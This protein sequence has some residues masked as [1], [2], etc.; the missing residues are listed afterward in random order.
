MNRSIAL[1]CAVLCTVSFANG[2]T[3]DLSA[4]AHSAVQDSEIEEVVV[5]ARKRAEPISEVPMAVSAVEA[6]GIWE[7][8]VTEL[9]QLEKQLPNTVQTNFGQGNTNQAVV[10]IRGTGMQDHIITTDPSVGIYLDGVYLGR[11]VGANIDLLGIDRIEVARGPQ[12]T[13]S[14]RN[15]LGGAVHIVTRKP[16]GDGTRRV[17]LRAGSLGRLSVG[18][19]LDTAIGERSD[20][21]VALGFKSRNGIGEA[22]LI[23]RPEAEVGEIHQYFGRLSWYWAVQDNTNVRLIADY[24][25]ARQGITPHEVLV[26]AEPNSLGLRQQDQPEDPNDT[27]SLNEELMS[28]DDRSTGFALIVDSELSERWSWKTTIGVRDMWFDAGLDNE[29]IAPSLLEF[30]ETGESDQLSFEYQLSSVSDRGEWISGLYYFEEDG[31]N[32]SPFIFRSLP[33]SSDDYFVPTSDFE[34][35][36]FVEQQTTSAALFSHRTMDLTEKVSIG[37]GL[38]HTRDD[39]KAGAFL[40]YFPEKVVK[41]KSWSETTGDVSLS[42]RFNRWSNGYASFA[43]GYQAGGFPPRPFAGPSVFVAFDPTFANSFELG[44]KYR[45]TRGTELN[46]S[47]FRVGYTDLAVQVSELIEDGFLTLT[48]NA[49]RSVGTGIEADGQLDLNSWLGLQFAVGLIDIEISEVDDSVQD[50]RAGDSPSLTPDFTLSLMPTVHYPLSHGAQLVGRMNWYT[51]GEMYG[52]PVNTRHNKMPS[53]SV[54]H[55]NVDYESAG[56]RWTIGGYVQNATDEQYPL[57]KLDLYPTALIIN[58][59]D[60]RE[61]GVRLRVDLE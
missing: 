56:G 40:H 30:P 24:S 15:T 43:R 22:L 4:D 51:R 57:A 42:Y 25:T 60:V 47:V 13:F 2:G 7:R 48:R 33:S 34:G 19:L 52:E 45:N 9:N 41:E 21:T 44:W 3:A 23:D 14:G 50:I 46:L 55:L 54:V 5:T 27:Y 39:K 37:L 53:I 17:D 8:N 35:L 12:G 31:Y 49:A 28:T 58:S 6:W 59:N 11:N 16:V 36:L 18:G 1:A 32:D 29:K 20:L 38:R 10:F 61:F 26:Y